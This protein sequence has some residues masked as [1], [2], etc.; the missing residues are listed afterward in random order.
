MC[1]TLLFH[2]ELPLLTQLKLLIAAV[3]VIA[4]VL[5]FHLAGATFFF[6]KELKAVKFQ[7]YSAAV[8]RSTGCL[9]GHSTCIEA[10]AAR[11]SD[12]LVLVA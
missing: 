9:A 3:I 6:C 7:L 4:A 1:A 5:V 2:A 10:P 8:A 12:L 11:N